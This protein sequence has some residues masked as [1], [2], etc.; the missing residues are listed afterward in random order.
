MTYTAKPA[1]MRAMA[2]ELFELVESGKIQ[3]SIH[4]EFPLKEVAQAHDAL[5]GRATTGSTILIP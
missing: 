1:D 4:Q 5:E 2:A 3:I